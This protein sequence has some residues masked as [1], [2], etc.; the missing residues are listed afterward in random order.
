MI[1]IPVAWA[2]GHCAEWAIHKFILHDRGKKKASFWSFHFHEHHSV[3]RR[4]NHHDPMYDTH[5]FKWNAAGKELFGLGLLTVAHLPLAP[6]A[7]FFF[8]TLVW[9]GLQYYRVHKR[10]HVDPEWA[11]EHLAWHYDHHMGPN[12]DSNWGVRSDW[13]DRMMGTREEY[14]GTAK[15]ARDW[16]RRQARLAA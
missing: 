3:S 16:E 6:V 10:A 4:S 8:G 7:P 9:S 12:Q 15:E 1:G 13:V 11:R 2:Y 14:A 5:P